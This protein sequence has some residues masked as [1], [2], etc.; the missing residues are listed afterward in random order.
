MAVL[1]EM[2][3]DWQSSALSTFFLN[4]RHEFTETMLHN[5]GWSIVKGGHTVMKHQRHSRRIGNRHKGRMKQNFNL[6]IGSGFEG[7]SRLGSRLTIEGLS[8][9]K[10]L[11]L[12]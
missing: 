6:V 9:R 4:V 8:L 3:E 11:L 5:R 10:Q 7:V 1:I 12:S 2:S